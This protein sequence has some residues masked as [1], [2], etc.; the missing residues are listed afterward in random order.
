[1][2]VY[3]RMCDIKSSISEPSPI[4][5]DDQFKLNEF[6]LKSF[7]DAFKEVNPKVIFICDH[8]GEDYDKMI[9][10]IV[11]FPHD[12]K[13]TSLGID[14]TCRLQ[15]E[16][17]EATDED[18]V[19]FQEA[20]YLYLPDAGKEIVEAVEKLDFVTPYDHPDKYETETTPTV[21]VVGNRHWKQTISTTS[22]FATK[23]EHFNA[24]RDI[25]YK[26][27]YIDHARWVEINEKGGLLWS[28]LPAIATHMVGKY[29]SP[30]VDWQLKTS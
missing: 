21:Q 28:A 9:K 13:H 19:L 24:Y 20:D 30:N 25:F 8:C 10:K 22:T 23:R 5:K 27:G 11:P 15:Y 18:A 14:G 2:I 3:M 12:I 1:M 16:M 17:Y 29:L 6:C 4:F 7:V 26:H